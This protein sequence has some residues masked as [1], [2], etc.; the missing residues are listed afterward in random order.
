MCHRCAPDQFRLHLD[1][2][3]NLLNGSSSCLVHPFRSYFAFWRI[4]LTLSAL[5]SF[6]GQL[7]LFVVFGCLSPPG[8][9]RLSS[10][11]SKRTLVRWLFKSMLI[12]WGIRNSYLFC[13]FVDWVLLPHYRN[14]SNIT[15]CTSL[16]S[17]AIAINQWLRVYLYRWSDTLKRN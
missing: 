10:F 3:F 4:S 14:C 8:C 16:F 1:A 15:I 17:G 13:I 5:F 7:T 11:Y 6:V 9:V 12:I 2:I